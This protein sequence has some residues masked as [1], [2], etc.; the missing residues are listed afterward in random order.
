MTLVSE[1]HQENQEDLDLQVLL[2][3]GVNW[4]KREFQDIQVLGDFLA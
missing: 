1:V 4:G 3:I 2:D